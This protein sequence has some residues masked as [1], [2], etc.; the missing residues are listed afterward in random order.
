MIICPKNIFG[1]GNR[2]RGNLRS[3]L[4]R[5]VKL[6]MC[7][8]LSI[9]L[10]IFGESHQTTHRTFYRFTKIIANLKCLENRTTGK[11]CESLASYL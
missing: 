11:V 7:F 4:S 6:H 8:Y 10:A 2:E 1:V 3:F 5:V 9:A